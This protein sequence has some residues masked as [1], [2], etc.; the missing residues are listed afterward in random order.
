[1]IRARLFVLATFS[2]GLAGC[3]MPPPDSPSL[4]GDWTLRSNAA[5]AQTICLT[6][7]DQT[8]TFVSLVCD[9]FNDLARPSEATFTDAS[10]EFTIS[11]SQ[12]RGGTVFTGQFVSDDEIT[13]TVSS[14]DPNTVSSG[15]GV[16]R[17]VR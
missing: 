9:E 1:M 12:D 14:S 4:E 15:S 3:I 6:F 11:F 17:R 5:N 16:M 13:F 10:I 7:E 8:L 2:V